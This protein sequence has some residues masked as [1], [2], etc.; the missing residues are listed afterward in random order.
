MTNMAT[1]RQRSMRLP[2]WKGSAWRRGTALTLGP[3]AT[4]SLIAGCALVPS[5]PEVPP[6]GVRQDAGILSVIVPVCPGDE[7][8]LASVVKFLADRQPDGASWSAT[9]F[10]GD[11]SPGIVLGPGDWSVVRGSYRSLTA[12]SIDVSTDRH[13]YGTAVEPS[14]LDKTKSLP[15]G[16]FL[17][18][19]EVMTGPE[20]AA[21]VSHF[22][23]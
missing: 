4:V 19:D 21:D 11:R 16:A 15:S 9:G 18:N 17:V 13:S 12:F 10:K 23:C 22:H 14:F 5:D 20:Y 8:R 2:G 1:R 7:V 6:V 3:L